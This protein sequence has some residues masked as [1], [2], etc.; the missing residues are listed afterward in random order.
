MCEGL[1]IGFGDRR[2]SFSVRERAGWGVSQ[3]VQSK[4]TA[5]ERQEEKQVAMVASYSTL[6][7]PS[8]YCLR[9]PRCLG[10]GDLREGYAIK[11][12]VEYIEWSTVPPQPSM[13]TQ[14]RVGRTKSVRDAAN[15]SW[16]D[17]SMLYQVEIPKGYRYSHAIAVGGRV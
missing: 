6:R 15:C 2:A 13:H 11:G 10:L 3:H 12:C 1:H 4:T 5:D 14:H 16:A 8:V 9:A 7:I 17:D